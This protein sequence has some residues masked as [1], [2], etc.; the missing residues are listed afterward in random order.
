MFAAFRRQRGVDQSSEFMDRNPEDNRSI[1]ARAY[2]WATTIIVIAGEMVVPGLI[3]LFVGRWLGVGA[4]IVL[5]ILGF[6]VG[7]M[8]AIMHLMRLTKSKDVN[9]L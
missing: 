8:V 5:A 6:S 3:G 9:Q 2:A 1:I 4:M 7:M